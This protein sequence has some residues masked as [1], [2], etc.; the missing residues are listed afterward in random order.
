M[1]RASVANKFR[2]INMQYV[3]QKRL[4]AAQNYDNSLNFDV[5]CCS[6]RITTDSCTTHLTGKV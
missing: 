3:L 6:G 5:Y 1:G 2:G 4:N